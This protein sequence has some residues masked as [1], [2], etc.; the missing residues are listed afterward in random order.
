MKTVWKTLLLIALILLVLFFLIAGFISYTIYQGYQV[1]EKVDAFTIQS[2]DLNEDCS[3]AENLKIS[4]YELEA[5]INSACGNILL[6]WFFEK[7]LQEGICDETVQDNY[8]DII[9]KNIDEKCSEQ[10]N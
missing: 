10:I 1:K 2:E 3:G 6:R 5:E 7:N 9:V 8:V 4:L